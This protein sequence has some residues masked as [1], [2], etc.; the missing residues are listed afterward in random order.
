MA[1]RAE[2]NNARQ[3]AEEASRSPPLADGDIEAMRALHVE[4]EKMTEL[5]SMLA[6]KLEQ[7]VRHEP[8]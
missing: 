3:R 6:Q 4:A 2:L 1:L 5:N 8:V 7:E